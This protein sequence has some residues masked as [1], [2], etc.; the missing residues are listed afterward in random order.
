MAT[1]LMTRKNGK[2][3]Y[4]ISVYRGKGKPY[5]Y[6]TWNIPDGWSKT[7]IKRGLKKAEMDAIARVKSGEAMTRS[8][9]KEKERLEKEAQDRALT[10]KKYV[11]TIYMPSTE[12]TVAEHTRTSLQGI[13]R[14]HIF[15][16][17]G[18]SKM[19]EIKP[20]AINALLL[21]MQKNGKK[22]STV[23]K[24]YNT[25]NNLF[26]NA[27]LDETIPGNPMGKIARPKATKAEKTVR[28]I[29]AFTI[30]EI[31][32][33]KDCAEKEPL[34]WRALLNL[35]IDTGCR[36]GEALGLTWDNVHSESLEVRFEGNLCYTP[37][38][39]VYVDTIKNG[40]AR[41]NVV[42]EHTMQLLQDLHKEQL[43]DAVISPYVFTQDVRGGAMHSDSP[44][45]YIP[46]FC[47]KY[48]LPECRPHKFRHSFISIA[49][50]NGADIASVAAIVG[51]NIDTILR[52]YTHADEDSKAKA[53]NVYQ[54]ALANG[55]K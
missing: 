3:A 35:F 8:D 50:T 5:Y 12:I 31:N 19:V 29:D 53:A 22:H 14:T 24:V 32:Y 26:K 40:K 33:I 27:Y 44:S 21:N 38:R 23:V 10:L 43:R 13:F 46:K 51:D 47:K 54:M 36:R 1:K 16:V 39:G 49:I 11:E 6:E 2:G 45:R 7:A 52:I 9:K 41:T 37:D 30:E 28:E 20:V 48:G 18:D 4:L 55:R 42:T 25:L 17:L 15:P 34:K